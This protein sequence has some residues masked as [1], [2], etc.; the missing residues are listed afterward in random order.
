M[1]WLAARARR[2]RSCGRSGKRSASVRPRASRPT[3]PSSAARAARPLSRQASFEFSATA[4]GESFECNLDSSDW[5]PC[6]SPQAYSGLGE[7]SH[8]FAVRAKDSAGNV[9]ASPATRTWAIDIAAPDTSIVSGPSGS[10]TTRTASFAF[11]A[12]E[13]AATFEC[14]LDAE[15]WAAC[16]SPKAYS[17]LA[18]GSHTFSVRAK[19][20]FGTVDASPATRT[21]MVNAQTI[22]SFT[23]DDGDA[24]QYQVKDLLASRGMRATFFVNSPRIGTSGFH[25]SWAQ[26]DAL[27]ADGNEIAG[28]TL[29][30]A[31]LT[32]P[33]LTDAQKRAEVCDDRQ[34][35]VARG[36]D[37]VSFAYPTGAADAAA[38]SILTECGYLLGRRVG[39]I[40]SPNWCPACASPAQSRFR[41]RTRWWCARRRSAPARS[42]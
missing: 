8:T 31:N 18:N 36:Y 28:H 16:T 27:A 34:N 22:V 25:M 15:D 30:H 13:A 4:T 24:T 26:L 35:L 39:G 11:S 37:P 9:D 17:G 32:D 14:K 21:W 5:A 42:P 3:P 7:G 1:D 33:A 41:R 12:S 19:D 40:V 6:S 29:T 2:E 38:Q 23:F 10:V 20:A